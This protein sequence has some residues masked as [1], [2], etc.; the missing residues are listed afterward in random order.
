MGISEVVNSKHGFEIYTI[1]EKIKN[2]GVIRF[3]NPKLSIGEKTTLMFS[4]NLMLNL[5]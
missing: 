3:H 2:L 5:G 1:L 4:R